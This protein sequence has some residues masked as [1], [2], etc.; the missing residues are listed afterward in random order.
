[1]KPT[2]LILLFFIFFYCGLQKVFSQID[3]E[4][5]LKEVKSELVKEWPRNRTINLVF[6]GHSVPSGYFKTPIVNTF[7]SYPLQLLK[8]LKSKYPYAVINVIVTSI[9]GEN[10]V[11]GESRF[12][13]DV[14]IH[15]PDVLFIDYALNDI[16]IGLEKS[17]EAMKKMI[18]E[19]LAKKIKVILLTPSPDQRIDIKVDDNIL[20]QFSNQIINLAKEYHIGVVNSYQLF[21]SQVKKGEDLKDLMSHINHPNERGHHLIANDIAKWF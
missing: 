1:M 9:G 5:Y 19:A 15:K 8:Q 17:R 12:P 18:E 7:G 4:E 2:Y 6:H 14:L 3:K 10:S 13:K 11:S 21:K 16:S 20:E